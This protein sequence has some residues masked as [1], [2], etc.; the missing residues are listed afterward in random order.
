VGFVSDSE[1]TRLTRTR[2]GG[3]AAVLAGISYGAAGYLDT[4]GVS[5]Y[6]SVLVFVLSVTTPTF[7]FGGLLGLRAL[8]AEVGS[9]IE[10]IG[11]IVGCLGTA[12]GG[13]EALINAIGLEQT[14]L[15]L[16]SIGFWW[17]AIFLVGL[18]LLGLA[19]MSSKAWRH[20]GALVL[21]SSALGWVSLLTDPAFS[22]VLVPMRTVHVSFAVLF[23]ISA[24]LW[25]WMLFRRVR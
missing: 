16:M 12:L 3:V 9:H 18:T 21:A 23:C 2:W 20:L 17:W 7:F 10:R 8:L 1:R 11:F 4:P 24:I 5:G 13:V 14:F 15:G 6:A 22:G 25:G 19:A